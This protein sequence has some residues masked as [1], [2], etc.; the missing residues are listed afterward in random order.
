M[1]VGKILEYINEINST[2]EREFLNLSTCFPVVMQELR[3][4]GG[5]TPQL[6]RIGTVKDEFS[7]L[8][9]KQMKVTDENNAALAEFH[10]KNDALYK[11]FSAAIGILQNMD[12]ISR[13][14]KEDSKEMEIISLNAMV[15]SIK[16]GAEGKAFS[17]ITSYLKQLSQHLI[18]QVDVFMKSEGA[19][20]SEISDLSR[21]IDAEA[22]RK[23]EK[24]TSLDDL[25]SV[26]GGIETSLR[27]LVDSSALIL[28]PIRSAMEGIQEQDIIRQS[29]DDI[30]MA[31]H[32]LAEPPESAAPEDKLDQYSMNCQLS[33]LA[34]KCLV[35]IGDDLDKSV[36]LFDKNIMEANAILADIEKRRKGF[37]ESTLGDAAGESGIQTLIDAAVSESSEFVSVGASYQDS[38]KLI[39]RQIEQMLKDV[40]EMQ[41]CIE[42]F[43]PIVTNLQHVAVAQRIEVARNQA[44]SAIHSTVEYMSE[45][46]L[47]TNANIAA[48]QRLL[49]DFV[50][51]SREQTRDFTHGTDESRRFFESINAGNTEFIESLEV[52]QRGLI[53]ALQGFTVYSKNF[54]DNYASIT[55][56]IEGLKG[57][58]AVCRKAQEEMSGINAAC[59]EQ[60]ERCKTAYALEDRPVDNAVFQDFLKK[61]TI[62]DD[63][64]AIA[65]VGGMEVDS[66]VQAGEITLF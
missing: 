48:A 23:V 2:S 9:E 20:Q 60:R 47:H 32:R 11:S 10:A 52:M 53:Q 66:G 39:R 7:R 62:M 37:I 64:L 36:A 15:V 17:Y 54:Y 19:I 44:I 51:S 27:G 56:S 59:E 65:S 31:V 16:S 63:K 41:G 13:K 49:S 34:A 42:S 21:T 30:V 58:S 8:L 57:L 33:A 6:A 18:R 25:V 28:P 24:N 50:K 45:L 35:H 38:Q 61:F 3:S 46:I 4:A 1:D 12:D 26:I 29:L 22:S 5:G 14:I 40:Q 55:A 43:V